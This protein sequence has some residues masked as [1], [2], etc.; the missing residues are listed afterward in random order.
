MA[1]QGGKACICWGLAASRQNFSEFSDGQSGLMAVVTGGSHH[2][3][4]KLGAGLSTARN[5]KWPRSSWVV[6]WIPPNRL[7]SRGCY[8][9]RE[10]GGR[11]RT[12]DCSQAVD[13]VSTFREYGEGRVA[14]PLFVYKQCKLKWA[15]LATALK[16]E[17]PFNVWDISSNIPLRPR[18]AGREERQSR[19]QA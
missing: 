9:E 2:S 4:R 18:G 17:S 15:N 6:L 10:S 5:V 19:T 1:R 11:V 13:R 7:D 16:M 3:A 12:S 14:V 8:A